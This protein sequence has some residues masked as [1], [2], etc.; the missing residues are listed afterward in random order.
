MRIRRVPTRKLTIALVALV[1]ILLSP[2][3]AQATSAKVELPD[4]GRLNEFGHVV[5]T[6]KYTCARSTSPEDALLWLY[7][8]QDQADNFAAGDTAV[9]ITCDGRGHSYRADLGPNIGDAYVRGTVFLEAFLGSGGDRIL[10][11]DTE[12]VRVR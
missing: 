9:A 2:T 12:Q 4:R 1:A 11:S 10:A 6:V 8:S 3:A 7:S 5:L